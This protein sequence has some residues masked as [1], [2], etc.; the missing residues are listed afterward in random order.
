MAPKKLEKGSPLADIFAD[1][2]SGKTGNTLYLKP[3]DTTIKLLM[4]AGETDLRKFYRKYMATFKGEQF[5]YFLICGVVTEATEDGVADEKRIRYIKCT[6]T[7]MTG[8]ANLLDKKWDLFKTA[9]P[10]I[11][12]TLGKKNGKV[13]YGVMAIPDQFDATSLTYPDQTIDEAAAEQEISSAELDAKN[14]DDKAPF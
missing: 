12:I 5:P 8:I 4:P 14:N 7:V 2:N 13:E 11:V 1:L 3:G 6:R 9:G 10:Q